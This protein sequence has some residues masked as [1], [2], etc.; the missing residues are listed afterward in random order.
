MLARGCTIRRGASSGTGT[1]AEFGSKTPVHENRQRQGCQRH[2]RET[3]PLAG[4]FSD[5]LLDWE[6]NSLQYGNM[7]RKYE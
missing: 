4:K 1:T 2:R 6:V 5:T 3:Y 7:G